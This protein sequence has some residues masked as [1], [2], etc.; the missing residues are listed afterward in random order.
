M[1]GVNKTNLNVFKQVRAGGSHGRPTN[2]ITVNG[3]N[4]PDGPLSF[5]SPNY[6]NT[7]NAVGAIDWNI[8]DKDQIRGRYLYNRTRGL[9]A[10]RDIAG[11]LEPHRSPTTASRFRNSTISRPPWKTSCA[12]RTSATTPIRPPETSSFPAW[13]VPESLARRSPIADRT[14]S[15][16]AFGD[17]RKPVSASG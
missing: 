3:V 12:F 8:S 7:Y 14:G 6:N 17:H 15:E 5:A 13:T 2:P 11:L 16:H 10:F 4:I 9:D 1:S